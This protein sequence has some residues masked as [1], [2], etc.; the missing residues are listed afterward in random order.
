MEKRRFGK[1][2]KML[3]PL[4]FGCMRLPV[5]D[6]VY[7]NIDEREAIKQIRYAIDKGVNY[8]DTAYPYHE[9]KSEALVGKALKDGYREK[10][11]LATKLPSWL[12]QTRDDMD[13]YL[14]EQLERL[15]TDTIDFYLIHALNKKYWA[16]YM[17][18]GLF[19][20]I[21]KAKADGRI[22]HIGFSFHDELD[23]FKEIVDAYDWEF[24]LIQYNFMDEDYQAGKEGLQYA[25]AKDLGLAIMEPLRGGNLV[26]N[27]PDDVMKI[28]NSSKIKR[29][30]AQW[31]LSFLW[32]Q[33]EVGLVLSGMN[34]YDHID[35][36]LQEASR[37][38]PNTLSD[39]ENKILDQVK[40]IY[41]TRTRVNCTGCKYCMPCPLG[42]DI[43]NAFLFYN[44]ASM[45]QDTAAAKSQYNI[46]VSEE[47]RASVCVDCGKCEK[48]CPQNLE[49]RNLLKDVSS[50]LEV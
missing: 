32:N 31:A 12:I 14:N 17:A 35:E 36:N 2:E 23:L 33:P 7:A 21:D 26:N 46:F 47:N 44:N 50:E 18:L 40:N 41:K 37:V 25:H 24:C 45:Y 4:G 34:D 5:V 10:V 39:E 48:V 22:K 20:F 9:G 11:Y 29:S 19:D 3:S 16:N 1:T 30:P 28:W 27:I 38:K 43:P 6:G 42:V 49:I 13:K 8:I 15:Q